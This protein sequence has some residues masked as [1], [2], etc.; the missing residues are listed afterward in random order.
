MLYQ[1]PKINKKQDGEKYLIVI[2][3]IRFTM[4]KLENRVEEIIEGRVQKYVCE[5]EMIYQQLQ[6]YLE[7][8]TAING[9]KVESQLQSAY[10]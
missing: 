8:K 6:V 5:R 7:L 10:S 1:T 3:L 2:K 4:L 9:R